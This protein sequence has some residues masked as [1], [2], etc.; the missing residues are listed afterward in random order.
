MAAGIAQ[1]IIGVDGGG[2][3]CRVAVG[4]Q[5]D[6]ILAQAEGG[7]ANVS[8]DFEGSVAHIKTAVEQATQDAG[9]PVG[10]LDQAVVHLGLAGA[11]FPDLRQR[12]EQALPYGRICVTGDRQTTV[13]G[14]LG[15]VDGF[16]VALGTGTIIARQRAGVIDTVSGWGFQLSDGASGAW[17]GRC[18]LSD[19]LDAEDGLIPSSPL[20]QS[21]AADLGGI[22]GICG[23]SSSATPRDY[24]TFAPQI[25]AAAKQSDT[26]A[27]AV[28]RS[29]A[30]Y[31][32]K[33]LAALD[34]TDGSV[35]ALAGGVGPHYAPYL[36]ARFT[37]NLGQ[38]QGTA[39]QGAFTLA[40]A[41][42]P[43]P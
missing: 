25:F 28:L 4:T 34:W 10:A 31:I 7:S 35:L 24:A 36:D 21:I 42:A 37:D 3:G 27:M 30:A 43:A 12:T 29:G 8:T 32:E 13:A 2:S 19:V 18:L 16:V 40:L 22:E 23:F 20:S 38:T 17:L 9:L 39:L 41:A 6:G 11:D 5:K 15:P 33:G 26:I 1:I 14:V